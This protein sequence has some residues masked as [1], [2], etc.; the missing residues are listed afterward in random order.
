VQCIDTLTGTAAP[1]G[2]DY[3]FSTQVLTFTAGETTETCTVS[4]VRDDDSEPGGETVI[5]GFGDKGTGDFPGGVGTNATHTLTIDDDDGSGTARF[6]STTYTAA[7]SGGTAQ[8]A[9]ER[10][11]GSSG[12]INATCSTVDQLS[13]VPGADYTATP[14]TSALSWGPGDTATKYCQVAILTDATP[15]GPETFGLSLT[16]NVSSPTSATVTIV[17]DDG[18]GTLQFTASS[19]S[20]AENGGGITVVVTRSGGTTGTVSV[21]VATTA[22]GS[23]AIAGLD[24]TA[25]STTLTFNPGDNSE[26]WTVYPIDDG[27]VEGTEHFHVFLSDP[28]GG[29][30]LGTPST[31]QV[32]IT[33]NESPLPAISSL[34]PSSGTILGGTLVTITG[35][36]FS[37]ATSVTFGGFSCTSVNVASANTITCVTPAHV[38]GTVEVVVTTPSGSNSTTGAANDYTYTGGP[39]ITSLDPATGL[40]IGNTIVTITGTNFTASGMTV[41]FDGVVALHS[42][43]DSTTVVAVAP[44]HSAGVV[45]V[46]VTTPG[47][48][49][50]NTAADDFTYTGASGP[51][52][53]SLSPASGPVGTTVTISGSGLTGATL[54]SFGGVAATFTV[55]NDAQITASVPSGTPI[56]TVDVRVT[57]PSGT[58]PNTAADNFNNTSAAATVSYTL[59]F[60][61]TLIVW[62]GQNNVSALAALTGLET[63]VDN[64]N[65]NN[66][67][68]LVGAIW[69]FDAATQTFKGYFPGSDN[70][71]GANDFTTLQSGV[72]YFV[73][74]LNPGT[75]TW[76]AL[77][78]Q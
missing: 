18:T 52:V 27:T 14:V 3:S 71:P 53:S 39:T 65:T 41:R 6:A 54:V 73:A 21:D 20:G 64:P 61:F 44:P 77:G 59:F 9:V 58:S 28:T 70:V 68:G 34:S 76:T 43:V 4:I 47:G 49:S 78:A 32:F 42:F 38:A 69:R 29:A 72:G 50:P 11:N 46:S 13:A 40:A 67:S 74:L 10:V 23:T 51:V 12:T 60:R 2:N 33:D 56:G 25:A 75:I 8:F 55:N 48:T 45:D 15:E 16:G 63:P 24:Y 26:S 62:T 5:L 7:E 35:V 37:G 17:D 22:S 19:Y 36:N 66:V 1:G 31:T 30:T 57:T